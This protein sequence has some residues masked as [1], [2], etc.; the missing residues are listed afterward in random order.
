MNLENTDQSANTW[1]QEQLSKP[2]NPDTSKLLLE[3]ELTRLKGEPLRQLPSFKQALFLSVL[4]QRQAAYDNAVALSWEQIRRRYQT[5]GDFYLDMQEYKLYPI[6]LRPD[7]KQDDR[8][9]TEPTADRGR[10]RSYDKKEEANAQETQQQLAKDNPNSRWSVSHLRVVEWLIGCY[11]K[12]PEPLYAGFK[13]LIDNQ[14]DDF[15]VQ[16]GG[17]LTRSLIL[18]APSGILLHAGTEML[19]MGYIVEFPEE[20]L[21]PTKKGL[22]DRLKLG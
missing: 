20:E 17:S 6:V 9:A 8:F 18:Q 14:L 13:A 11:G 4:A 16:H 1:L 7:G 21:K 15:K 10:C 3:I 22:L 2:N 12:A 5:T 19:L